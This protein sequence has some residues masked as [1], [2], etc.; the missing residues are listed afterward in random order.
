MGDSWQHTLHLQNTLAADPKQS[1]PRPVDGAGR[2][3]PQDCGGIP[4]FCHLLDAPADPEH[5]DRDDVTDWLGGPFDA[6]D[7]DV[8]AIHQRL[9]RLAARRKEPATK[10]RSPA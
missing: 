5:P 2:C 7:M 6:A 3:P 4:G 8:P 9:A 10:R 1:D